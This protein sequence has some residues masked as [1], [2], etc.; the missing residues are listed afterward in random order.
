MLVPV[1]C[2]SYTPHADHSEEFL[3][4]SFRLLSQR[5]FSLSPRAEDIVRRFSYTPRA[6]LSEE[7]P[8]HS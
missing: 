4:P 8:L 7:F 6:G 2:F 5:E 1:R 3:T